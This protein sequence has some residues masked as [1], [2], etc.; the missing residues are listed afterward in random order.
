MRRNS[1][2][3]I[4][5]FI[6]L[7]GC[8]SKETT[9][10]QTEEKVNINLQ[11]ILSRE[12]YED[13][14]VKKVVTANI[15]INELS[16]DAIRVRLQGNHQFEQLSDTDKFELFHY[17][18]MKVRKEFTSDQLASV[19]G[20]DKCTLEELSVVVEGKRYSIRNGELWM[21]NEKIV[22]RDGTVTATSQNSKNK[23]LSPS[24]L[25][26]IKIG[27]W[28]KLNDDQ[29]L[30]AVSMIFRS[31]EKER[32]EIQED[33][34]FFIRMLDQAVREDDSPKDKLVKEVMITQGVSA[35]ALERKE[36]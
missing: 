30:S 14:R 2:L 18:T 25:R 26:E 23:M 20:G 36:S 5:F 34:R 29:K 16:N 9:E 10:P 32:Y 31:L 28:M 21:N 3:V 8:S 7:V 15:E 6:L 4:L 19:C 17:M 33:E 22:S 35:G 11:E 1:I 24:A 27:N 13:E 12:L